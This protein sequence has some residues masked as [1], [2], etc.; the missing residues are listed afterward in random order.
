MLVTGPTPEAVGFESMLSRTVDRAGESSTVG[1]RLGVEAEPW[2][3]R[4]QLRAGSYIEPTR[5]KDVARDE[6]APGCSAALLAD[7]RCVV[8]MQPRPRL[9]G[10][11]GFELRLFEWDIFGIAA[12]GTSWRVSAAG[13]YARDYYGYSIAVGVWH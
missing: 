7:P 5:F 9:H 10:T 2:P 12:E 4:L 13:D 11:F 1:A 3:N 8:G 6:N